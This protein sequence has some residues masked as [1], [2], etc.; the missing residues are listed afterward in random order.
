MLRCAARK[1]RITNW[2]DKGDSHQ[3]WWIQTER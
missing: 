3:I 2:A 1:L